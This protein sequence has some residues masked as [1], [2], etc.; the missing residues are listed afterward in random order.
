MNPGQ[1]GEG[2]NGLVDLQL[3]DSEL[4]AHPHGHPSELDREWVDVDAANVGQREVD[5]QGLLIAQAGIAPHVAGSA[6]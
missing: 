6:A 1:V 2:Q 4:V 3:L 5:G